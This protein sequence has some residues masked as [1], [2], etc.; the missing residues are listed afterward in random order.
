MRSPGEMGSRPR[1]ASILVRE[2]FAAKASHVARTAPG[3]R[4]VETPQLVRVD[5]GL[6]SD[7]FNLAVA[8]ELEGCDLAALAQQGTRP[9]ADKGFPMAFW[10]WDS[11]WAQE[12]GAELE[13]LG[14]QCNEVNAAMFRS[15]DPPPARRDMPTG[16]AVRPA[17]S[18]TDVEQFGQVLSQLFGASQESRHVAEYFRR[19][20]L[21]QLGQSSPMRLYLGQLQ[22]ELV[23]TGALFL[24]G[25]TAGIYDLATLEEHRGE[26]FGTAVFGFLLQEAL[27]LGC[28]RAVLQ[29]SLDGL[30]I[31]RRAGFE[32]LC[33]VSVYERTR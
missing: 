23:S 12:L 28:R 22:G 10:V 8:R 3:M 20:D 11:A 1:E 6:P 5:C 21:A 16:F 31:Y 4:V 30:G 26:G 14:L 25:P 17:L 18:E 19:L 33:N 2:N 27:R 9:F 7:T 24:D 29:A 15:L 32:T 13:G